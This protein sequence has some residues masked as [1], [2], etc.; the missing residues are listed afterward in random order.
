ML[1]HTSAFHHRCSRPGRCQRP[2]RLGPAR[3]HEPRRGGGANCRHVG[4]ANRRIQRLFGR[5]A[6]RLAGNQCQGRPARQNRATPDSGSGWQR[7]SACAPPLTASKTSRKP[8]HCLAPWEPLRRPRCPSCCAAMRPTW[9]RS[10]PGCTNPIPP[11]ATTPLPYLPRA[12]RRS[13]T[14]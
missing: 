4:R 8:W 3:Q 2:A 1:L 10:P 9:P 6:H 13:T 11:G 7:R 12:R 5:L 14:R